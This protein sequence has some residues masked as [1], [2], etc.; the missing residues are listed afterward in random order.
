MVAAISEVFGRVNE[1]GN[2]DVLYVE[3]G[4]AVNR[5][6]APDVFPVG[7]EFGCTWDHPEGITITKEDA[8]RLVLDIE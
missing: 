6:D 5:L 8:I 7:S 2:V 3:T 4:E 1:D